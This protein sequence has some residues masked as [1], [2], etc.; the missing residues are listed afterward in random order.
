MPQSMSMLQTQKLQQTMAPQLRQS[1][2]ILQIPMMELSSLIQQEVEVNPTLE[3]SAPEE[4]IPEIDTSKEPTD[5]TSEMDL[6]N[7]FDVLAKIDSDLQDYFFQDSI[8]DN[9]DNA[10]RSERQQYI[11][12]SITSDETLHE[13]LL[14]QLDL[15]DLS[16]EDKVIGEMLIGSI[17]DDG[18]LTVELHELALSTGYNAEHL[19]DVLT[20]IQD[21]H[22]TGVG[23]RSI[24]ECL[25]MQLEQVGKHENS[26]E[27]KIIDEHFN[28]LGRKKL[29]T[30]A[31]NLG[32]S[33]EEVKIAAD[34]IS[35]QNPKPGNIFGEDRIEYILPEV[36]VELDNDVYVAR[37]NDDSLPKLRIS[38]YYRK[39]IQNSDTP[40][41]T[42]KYIKEKLASSKFLM[43]SIEQRQSTLKKISDVIVEKQ[44]D[45]FRYGIKQLKPMTMQE[46]AKS[47]SVHETTVSRAVSGKYM[48]TPDGIF[49]LRYFFTT[50]LQTA[51]GASV[52]NE[53]VKDM[54]ADMIE[55]EDTS[56]PLSDQV[57]AD[58][59]QKKGIN[60]A[61]RTVAKYRIK[62]KIPSSSMRRS[63]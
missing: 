50:G 52:S 10:I 20:V 51:D 40:K 41:E 19:N 58:I 23:A 55:N 25:H 30:I 60:V 7:E 26:L 61:R 43:T 47:V 8:Q 11:M 13:H 21:F 33:V 45:F 34:L 36:F 31:D 17:N 46:V 22:P 39:L 12:D 2:E 5:Q 3:V 38:S 54:I 16:K 4:S 6:Q 29:T 27:W 62:L 32:V 59:L 63:D 9:T 35:Q 28:D 53:S 42:I 57:I 56:K 44:Q 24:N 1:L 48:Q 18:Y 37:I 14:F 15:S 49:E